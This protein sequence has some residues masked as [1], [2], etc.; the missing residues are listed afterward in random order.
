MTVPFHKMHGLGN[1]F[2]ILDARAH[3]L[4]CDDAPAALSAFVRSLS[5]RHTGI[6][7]DQLII[8]RVGTL[9]FMQI[10]NQDGGEVSACG[11]ATR[12]VGWLLMQESGAHQVHIQTAAGMLVAEAREGGNVRVNMGAPRVQ[13]QEIPLSMPMDTNHITYE[14][15][16]D[17]VAV[18]MGNPHLVMFMASIQEYPLAA[19]GHALEHAS[20]FPERANITVANM[21][22]R[23][24]IA[25][26]TWERGVGETLACGTAACATMVA[27]RRRGIVDATATLHMAGG[28]LTLEWEGDADHP[29]HPVFMT[30]EAV[31]VFHGS[32]AL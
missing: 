15:C 5:N 13:W 21:L 18:S 2:V 31:Y 1:D 25:L 20:L 24:R 12:C 10:F 11:N 26:R 27:A 8:L 22:S 17:G 7:C 32:L 19:Q 4:P 30:G 28:T 14:H 16:H 3:P 29:N 23:E 9:P 6:G